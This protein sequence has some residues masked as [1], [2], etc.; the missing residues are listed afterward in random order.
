MDLTI[1]DLFGAGASQ[2]AQFLFIQKADLLGLTVSTNNRAEQ[3]LAGVVLTA[4]QQF[5]GLLSDEMGDT[6]IDES[7]NTISYN[8]SEL[9]DFYLTFWRKIFLLRSNTPCLLNQFVVFNYLPYA[10]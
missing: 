7:G 1:Q 4:S 5:E 9:Y 2:N 3:L 6:V 10:E 8:N